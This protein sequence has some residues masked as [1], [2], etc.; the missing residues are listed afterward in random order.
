MFSI[1]TLIFLEIILS[2]DNLVFLSSQASSLSPERRKFARSVGLFFG[3]CFRLS[4]LFFIQSFFD[5][6]KKVL[7]FFGFFDFNF[8]E[9]IFL[10]GGCFLIYKSIVE[11][12]KI[13]YPGGSSEDLM[14]NF[15]QEN[16]GLF[17]FFKRNK[18]KNHKIFFFVILEIIFIDFIFSI[19]SILVA[20]ALAPDIK[21]LALA[22]MISSST[23]FFSVDFLAKMLLKFPSMKL[24]C[25]FFIILIGAFFILEAFQIHIPKSYINSAFIFGIIFE[26]FDIIRINNL[27]KLKSTDHR[28]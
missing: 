27:E 1:L 9:L 13:L 23:L 12:W 14:Q 11:I 28:H 16:E 4:F 15:H 6:E 25:M 22:M 5:L 7:S 18:S 21:I 2:I 3:F 24:L 20:I 17:R 26:T 19:D 10:F 8:R